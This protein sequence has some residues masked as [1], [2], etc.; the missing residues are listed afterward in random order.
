[1][2][3][4]TGVHEGIS[5]QNAHATAFE[6]AGLDERALGEALDCLRVAVTLFDSQERLV[7]AN[8][9]YN[10]LLRSLPARERL[11]GH[12]YEQLIRLE[13]LGGEIAPADSR[14]P[15]GFIARRRAQLREGEY[16]PLDIHLADGRVV[17]IKARRT[18]EGGWIA[19][20]ND[21]TQ[22][23][24]AQLRLENAVSLSADAFAFFDQ[25]D[26]LAMCNDRY[27][28][29]YGHT[30]AAEAVGTKF[31]DLLARAT[32]E[33]LVARI[34]E[35]TASEGWLARRMAAHREP[36]GAMTVELATGEA[37]LL[38]D[39]ATAEGGRVVI[40]TD[41]T[42]H[43]RVELALA[44]QTRAL[45]E[46]RSAQAAQA[47]YLA[48]LSRRFDE[49]SISADNAKTTLMRTMSHELKTPLNAI[50]GFSDLMLT[51]ADRF[52][53]EKV[54][55]YAGLIHQGGRN[56]LRLINQILDLTRLS[57]GRYELRRTRLDAGAV[58]WAAHG[59][60][61]ARAA[62]KSIALD[63]SAAPLGLL[64]DA[65]ESALSSMVFQLVDNAVSFTQAGG[66]VELAAELADGGVCIRIRDNGP[67]VDD[68]ARILLPFEQGGRGTTDHTGGAGLGLTLVKAFTEAHGGTFTI[69]SAPG[70]GLTATIALPSTI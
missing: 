59:A 34:D 3:N 18:R 54:R 70:Q 68:I 69:E 51:M 62:E 1:L 42:D 12:T 20:W 47:D 23:R 17:E 40:F 41:V 45:A 27:A 16:R 11:I 24:H 35:E 5:V 13:V 46:T 31:A 2:R 56:L 53:Q 9:H 61:E 19:L 26:V 37:Y 58:I 14:D 6:P 7:Y 32:S 52:D 21:V 30:S 4:T 66:R 33:Q 50:I 15:D 39:R 28:S 22:A 10:Y 38:R 63:A 60:H 44:E 57:A 43:R 55:E 65:D 29:F 48:D 49:A 67:G 36:A 25:N 64:V 8:R